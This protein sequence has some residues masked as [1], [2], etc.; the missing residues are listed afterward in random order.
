MV[1]GLGYRVEGLVLSVHGLGY[2]FYVGHW[3]EMEER[4]KNVVSSCSRF[5]RER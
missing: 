1:Y 3:K 4:S 5:A 2:R